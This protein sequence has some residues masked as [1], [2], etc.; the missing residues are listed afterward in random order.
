MSQRIEARSPFLDLIALP[1][2]AAFKPKKFSRDLKHG[3]IA[4]TV[5]ECVDEAGKT[6]RSSEISQ[7][8]KLSRQVV[9]TALNE[10][11]KRG[12]IERTNEEPPFLYRSIR[13]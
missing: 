6:M 8:T 2:S 12:E 1:L 11:V 4:M 7:R 3:S 5:L 13:K 10:L 9:A